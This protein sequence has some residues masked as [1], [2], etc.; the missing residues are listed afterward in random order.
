L[1]IELDYE[2]SLAKEYCGNCRLCIDSCPTRAIN[3][4]KTIDARRCI[5]Y[6]TVESKNNVPEEFTGKMEERVFGCD[7]CQDVCPWNKNAKSHNLPELSLSS[8]LQEM[9]REEWLSLSEENYK[10]IFGKSAVRR[11]K[12]ERLMRNVRFVTKTNN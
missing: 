2:S 8:E 5:S 6:L 3:E 9:T 12:Y 1:N 11:L 7:K 4:N 10:N